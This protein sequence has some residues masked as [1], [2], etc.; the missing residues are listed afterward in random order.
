MNVYTA[1]GTMDP[2]LI[3][4]D[5]Q[6]IQQNFA[7]P[8][9][10]FET[11]FL[12]GAWKMVKDGASVRKDGDFMKLREWDREEVASVYSVPLDL[13][14]TSLPSTLNGT[15]NVANR[16]L[17]HEHVI[18]PLQVQV[19]EDMNTQ[20]VAGAL[21]NDSVKLEPP[22]GTRIRPADVTMAQAMVESGATGNQA[23]AVMNLPPI[24]G[25]DKPLYLRRGA[26]MVGVPGSPDSIVIAGSGVVSGAIMDPA[27]LAAIHSQTV[28]GDTLSAL[29]P[30][31]TD[32]DEEEDEV[33]DAER[34]DVPHRGVGGSTGANIRSQAAQAGR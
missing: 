24:T 19:M 9:Q 16:E 1:D 15:S 11:L 4:R 14:S 20:L 12:E 8:N 3:E 34:A 33:P 10:S 18:A 31:A 32:E 5:R 27:V 6:Y 30:D 21:G 29:M 25:L 7:N 17:F 23:L 2:A 22:R 26:A 28:T 13:L